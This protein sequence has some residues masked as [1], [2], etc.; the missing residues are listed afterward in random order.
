MHIVGIGVD[1]CDSE[2]FTRVV[3]RTPRIVERLFTERERHE[4]PSM[5]SLAARFATKEAVAKVLRATSGLS[6][7][8]CE[9]VM[10]GYG[11]PDIQVTGAAAERARILGIERWHVSISHDGGLS[12]SFVVAEG[13]YAGRVPGR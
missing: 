6:W 12:I 9:V 2:R 11:A 3:Q 4:K 8:E 7:Q 10:D 13:A 5:Q 1:I